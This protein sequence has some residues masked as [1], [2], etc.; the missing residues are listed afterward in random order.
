MLKIIKVLLLSILVSSCGSSETDQEVIYDVVPQLPGKELNVAFVL[1]D[2]VYNSELVAPMD[3]FHHTIFHTDPAMKVFTVAP[4]TSVIT[5]FE[6]LRIL[7]DYSFS[8]SDLPSIDIL[9]VPSA[10]HSM[11][12]DLENEALIGFVRD[13]GTT[14]RYVISLCDGAFVLAKAGFADGRKSTTFPSDIQAYKEMYP[15]LDVLSGVSFVHDGKLITSAGGAKSY[16]PALYLCELLYGREVAIGLAGGLVI[17]W[18]LA[19]IDHV[20]VP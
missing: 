6:G 8:S 2:G 4:D 3:I 5:T 9:V 18:D 7:P 14:A 19:G 17:D 20:V 10:E 13:K 12:K 11:N 1:V 15:D 16:D